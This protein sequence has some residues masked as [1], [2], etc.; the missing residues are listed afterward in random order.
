M[1]I[2]NSTQAGEYAKELFKIGPNCAECVLKA[3]IASKITE[4]SDRDVRLATGFGG[5]IGRYGLTCGALTGAVIAVSSVYG[6]EKPMRLKKIEL[7]KEELSGENGIYGLFNNLAADFENEMGSTV[8]KEIIDI[9]GEN[10]LELKKQKCQR[11]VFIASK[12]AYEYIT[13]KE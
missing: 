1:K 13:E 10:A 6:R 9:T 2:E 7:I 12:L 5:G 3:M 8:C 11:A 4:L